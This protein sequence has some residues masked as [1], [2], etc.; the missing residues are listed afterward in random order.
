MVV[1]Q[2]VSTA[3]APPLSEQLSPND[4]WWANGPGSCGLQVET[5]ARGR[6]QPPEGAV[7]SP[8]LQLVG[9]LGGPEAQ[10]TGWGLCLEGSRALASA[11]HWPGPD[12]E[13]A[14][15][16]FPTPVSAT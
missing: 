7:S 15:T 6:S 8:V 10:G 11:A 1:Q 5:E 13:V 3:L 12:L 9:E 16:F 2:L 4:R 14:V